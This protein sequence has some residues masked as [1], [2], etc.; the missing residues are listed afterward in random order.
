MRRA[1][2]EWRVEIIDVSLISQIMNV[3]GFL[4]AADQLIENALLLYRVYAPSNDAFED[5]NIYRET[6]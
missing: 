6:V 4:T 3:K 2:D 5:R 1:A